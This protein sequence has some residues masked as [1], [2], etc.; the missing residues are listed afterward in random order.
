MYT[1]SDH[2]EARNSVWFWT[3]IVAIVIAI[4]FVLRL[5]FAAPSAAVGVVEK[6]L[7]PNNV[8][9]KYE[10][11]YDTANKI[12]ARTAQ[13]KAHRGLIQAEPNAAEKTRLNIELAGQQQSCRDMVA[14]YNANAGKANVSIFKTDT[15]PV[16]FSPLVCE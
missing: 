11:F 7:D 9:T 10:W 2:K 6:T 15:T 8:I 16:A 12:T 13:I 5:V 4:G 3:M 14:Q 1:S